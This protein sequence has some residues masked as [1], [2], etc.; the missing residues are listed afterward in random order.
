MFTSTEAYLSDNNGKNFSADTN[1]ES[2]KNRLDK[3]AAINNNASY[4][5]ASRDI[6]YHNGVGLANFNVRCISTN[7][8]LSF[9]R[10]YYV[11]DSGYTRLTDS[12]SGIRPIFILSSNVKII[13]GEGTE[14]VPFEIGL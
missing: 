11:I 7:G 12:E 4:W 10:L 8:A 2:D 1:Y 6:F 13:D 5:L 14:E 3:I 9:F